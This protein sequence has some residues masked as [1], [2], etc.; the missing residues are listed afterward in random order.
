MPN[1]VNNIIKAKGINTFD[2]FTDNQVDFNKIIPMPESLNMDEGSIT[3]QAIVVFIT[4]K[5]TVAIDDLPEDHRLFLSNNVNSMFDRNFAQTTFDKLKEQDLSSDRLDEL[6]TLG[7]QYAYNVANYGFATWYQWSVSFWGT[8]W[9][10]YETS[11]TKDQVSFQTAWSA[12]IPVIEALSSMYPDTIITHTYADEDMGSNT[13]IIEY[14]NG[15]IISITQPE[16]Q[17]PQAYGIYVD[18]WGEDDYLRLNDQGEW[19]YF[20]RDDLN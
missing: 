19:E 20:D 9:N 18:V 14:L 5:L 7:K 4:D 15:R 2:I 16:P 6:N 1:H 10:A 17:S 3:D 13:G 12:P 11:V 8:K